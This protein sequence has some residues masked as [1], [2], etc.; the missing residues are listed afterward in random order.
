LKLPSGD[1]AWD[2]AGFV[3]A[4][5]LSSRMG[6]DKALVEFGGQ[7]LVA[8]AV[9]ILRA[10]GLPV[11]LAGARSLLDSYAPVVSDTEQ[12][13][14]PLAGICAA[15][16]STSTQLAFFLPVDM[17][18]LPSALIVYLLHHARVTGMAVT[19]PTVNA[20]PQTFPVV[21]TR[22]VL[23]VLKRELAEGRSGCYAAF[24][25]A[26]AGLGQSVAQ[27]PV[28]V[29]VQSGQVSHPAAIPPARWFLN[30][31]S[32]ADLDRARMV[33]SARVA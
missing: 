7:P 28:E 33:D 25:A 9:G 29:L 5:G 8:H 20:F 31:N 2:A 19:L 3:L 21:L 15:L 10:A 11:S 14:G 1:Q 16:H 13:L 18:L 17:P 6:R 22:E 4:G 24:R 27:L 30:I 23:P 26:A 12:G 32:P